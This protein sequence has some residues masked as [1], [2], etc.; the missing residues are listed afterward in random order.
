M[1]SLPRLAAAA[2]VAGWLV[3]V[4]GGMVASP[5]RAALPL[6]SGLVPALPLP[7]SA[8]APSPTSTAASKPT[9][10]PT[11]ALP[12]LPLPTLAPLPTVAIPT[13]TIPTLAP[14]PT[15]ALPT[16]PLPAPTAT[17]TDAIENARN[18]ARR[19]RSAP[20]QRHLRRRR[21]PMLRAY[22]G[23]RPA[24]AHRAAVP[25]M[26]TGASPMADTTRT[27]RAPATPYAVS[28]CQRPRSRF[29]AR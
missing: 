7:T 14:I 26:P 10:R 20:A 29:P 8:P 27:A 4:C 9:P 12:V 11:L 1:R 16:L 22:R 3:V 23:R 6:P 28:W 21:R 24:A 17:P 19:T 15:L 2:V 25:A 18:R 13:L 5:T